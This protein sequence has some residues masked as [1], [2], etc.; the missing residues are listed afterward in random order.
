MGLLIDGEWHDRWYDTETTGGEFVR[1]DSGFRHWISADGR[2][3]EGQDRSHPAAAGRYHLYVSYACPWAHRTLILRRL[4]GLDSL[5]GV[6][7][8]DPEM[9][10]HGWSFSQR[11]AL[12]HDP[13]HGVRHLYQ[14]Y[15]RARPDY[16][17]RATVPVL[18]DRVENTIVSNESAQILRMFN[19]AFDG[20]TGNELDFYPKPLRE[21]ID[22]HNELVYSNI[23]NGVYRCGFATRQSAY[24]RAY[25]RLFDA[26]DEV[27][28]ILGRQR[29]LCGNR[30]TE[31]DWR[32]FTT[33]LRFDPVYYGHFKCNRQRIADFPHL[34]GY[35]RELYQ[36]PEISD[37]VHLDHIKRHYYYS[38]HTI[39]PTRIVP[40][41]P[42][43]ALDA[44][45]DRE[46]L[47]KPE[48]ALRA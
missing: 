8:V 41:G 48:P 1:E 6:S 19:E 47:G 25:G 38:H 11:F 10:E 33:L 36:V 14:L 2:R 27:E 5:I 4:K 30:I 15:Q 22:A 44:A 18:W 35:L 3:P 12:N 28:E 7:V 9:L 20:L 24:E 23:N 42:R 39:N 32:L 45:H 29:Y 40:L 13:L 21:R 34:S 31:A 43:L 16:T 26:L 46:R 17:G 37:T